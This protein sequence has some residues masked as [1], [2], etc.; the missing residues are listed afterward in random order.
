MEPLDHDRTA[1]L[2]GSSFWYGGWQNMTGGHLNP[3]AFVRGLARAAQDAG[4]CVV[5]QGRV[6]LCG[7]ERHG[8]EKGPDRRGLGKTG[9]RGARSGRRFR[10]EPALHARSTWARGSPETRRPRGNYWPK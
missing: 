3:L 1:E 10:Q 9:A 5:R 4:A 7:D 8:C 6:K 2:T